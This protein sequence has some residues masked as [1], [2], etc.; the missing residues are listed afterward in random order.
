MNR[1]TYG[2]K[3]HD[4]GNGKF[5]AEVLCEPA[6]WTV[7]QGFHGAILEAHDALVGHIHS[8]IAGGK[9]I[10]RPLYSKRC[11][12]E[13]ELYND[14]QSMVLEYIGKNP[15]LQFV[16]GKSKITHEHLSIRNVL[17]I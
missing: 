16:K 6:I 17:D 4:R 12:A 7:G 3:V 11:S 14:L 5:E 2:V 8:A 15:E 9:Y 13:I 10:P 1:I